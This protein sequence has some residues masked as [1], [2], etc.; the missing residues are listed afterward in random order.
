M[1]RQPQTWI[2]WLRA[3]LREGDGNPI[4]ITKNHLAMMTGTDTRV[5]AAIAAVWDLLP[6]DQQTACYVARRL[7]PLM[8]PQCWPIAVELVARSLDWHDRD[9]IWALVDPG[10]PS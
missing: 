10:A 1:S 7:L 6:Y 5:L 4:R 9:R 2:Q 3:C 8:Q